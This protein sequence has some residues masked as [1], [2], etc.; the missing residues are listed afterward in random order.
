MFKIL[1]IATDSRFNA[2]A[3]NMLMF[4]SILF[5]FEILK[6]Y[7]VFFCIYEDSIDYIDSIFEPFSDTLI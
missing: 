3:I 7:S 5:E 4:C 1:K 2:N 6:L